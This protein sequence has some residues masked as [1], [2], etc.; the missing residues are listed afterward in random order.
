[1]I[2]E[3]TSF[4][5]YVGEAASISLE[6]E[7]LLTPKPGLVDQNDTGS[8]ND[9]SLEMMMNSASSLTSTFK[10]IAHISYGKSPTQEI[11]E[12]IAKIGRE[13]ERKMFESTN[14]INTHKGAVWALGLIASAFAIEKGQASSFEVLKIAGKIAQYSDEQHVH[15]LP[16]NGLKVISKY[17]VP[18]ARGEAALGFPTIRKFGLPAHN[19]YKKMGYDKETVEVM[20]LMTLI[21]NLS[22][23]CILHRGGKEGLRIAQSEANKIIKTGDLTKIDS[24][25]KLFIE[26][27]ISPGGSADL[28]AAIL[29]LNKLNN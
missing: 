17:N 29:F 7:V 13:G 21:A 20:T 16:T 12:E 6:A 25:N 18:G 10:E 22:D 28:L 2:T 1:M 9:L 23:T 19:Y 8:H 26:L 15:Q 5:K 3:I 4:S 14:N 24:M 11:R 27:N